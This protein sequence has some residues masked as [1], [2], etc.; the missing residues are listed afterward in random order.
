MGEFGDIN[1]K[2]ILNKILF[3]RGNL[4]IWVIIGYFIYCTFVYQANRC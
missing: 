2:G 4:P 1:I 3:D